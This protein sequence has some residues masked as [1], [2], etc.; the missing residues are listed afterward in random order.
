[1][2]W[3]DILEPKRK[4]HP[5]LIQYEN[6]TNITSITVS[7]YEPINE[8][9]LNETRTYF[10]NASY[11]G[12]PNASLTGETNGT[13]IIMIANL[14]YVSFI[15]PHVSPTLALDRSVKVVSSDY[16]WAWNDGSGVTVGII[17]SGIQ[18]NHQQF[19]STTIYDGIDWI[20]GEL[21]EAECGESNCSDGEDNDTDGKTDEGAHG[22]HVAG[23]ISG[24]STY[25]GR[26]IK[27]NS[28]KSDLTIVRVFDR[29]KV[30][31]DSASFPENDAVWNSV[32][33]PDGDYNFSEPSSADVI[34]N[35]WGEDG[36][37]GDY[38]Y[39]SKQVDRVVRGELSNGKEVTVVMSAGNSGKF[40]LINYMDS[41]S[42]SYNN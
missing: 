15:Y 19:S 33:D 8:V 3:F 18:H 32:L 13:K 27:G 21:P 31:V 6:S 5:D 22:V 20:N 10:V 25:Q 41:C 7:F 39:K 4:L 29:E 37:Y 24:S 23:I 11:F 17:D 12:E 2:I 1:M 38:N 42:L 35:S 16:V 40:S 34:S 9:Q 36:T 30:W 26:S 28:F 14:S